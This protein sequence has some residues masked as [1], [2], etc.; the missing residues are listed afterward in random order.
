MK[1][2]IYLASSA[3]I[4]LA[5]AVSSCK[6][7]PKK[8]PDPNP[9]PN[10]EQMIAKTMTVDATS[11]AKWVYVSLKKGEVVEVTNPKEDLSWDIAFH[12]FDVRLNGG[13]SGKGMGAALKSNASGKKTPL[14][15]A[16]AP[17]AEGWQVDALVDITTS[18]NPGGG[19]H[20]SSV[21]KQGANEVISGKKKG[22]LPSGGWIDVS[23]QMG[24]SYKLSHDIYFV[25]LADGS[26]ARIKLTDFFDAKLKP[27]HVKFSYEYPV[28]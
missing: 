2:V 25:K 9:N 15:D 20:S 22:G 26:M 12:R 6:K 23:M 16:G 4:M 14:K 5:V 7:E 18:F 11:Y 3:F 19:N 17:P 27:G 21:E 13:E 28:K 24:P 1:K 10:Q 8:N